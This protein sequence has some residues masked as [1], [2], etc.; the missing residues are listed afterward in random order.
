MDVKPPRVSSKRP[1]V[2]KSSQL[3]PSVRLSNLPSETVVIDPSTLRLRKGTQRKSKKEFVATPLE[4]LKEVLP[5]NSE[6]KSKLDLVIIKRTGSF[7]AK[8]Y[9]S[10]LL[11]DL[12]KLGAPS[13]LA[14]HIDTILSSF[15]QRLRTPYIDRK[16]RPHLLSLMAEVAA[17]AFQLG[18]E[19]RSNTELNSLPSNPPKYAVDRLPNEN[20]VE[21]LKRVWGPYDGIVYQDDIKRLGDDKLVKAVRN[22]CREHQLD[23]ASILPPPGYERTTRA[24]EKADPDSPTAAFYRERLRR[25]DESA[26]RRSKKIAIKPDG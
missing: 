21:F 11:H 25:R 22:Y 2:A 3:T 23:A 1:S 24:L 14:L 9:I 20:A 26:R 5:S 10:P 12:E 15:E 13:E 18:A 19:A 8:E 16:F 17:S 6:L 4:T 7:K